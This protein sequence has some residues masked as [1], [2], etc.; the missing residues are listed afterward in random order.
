MRIPNMRAA[1]RGLLR[2]PRLSLAIVLCVA[3]GMTAA[4]AV[5]AFVGPALLR[6]LPFPD[7]ERLVRVWLSSPGESQRVDLS[8]PDLAD[9]ATLRTLDRLEV[10]GRARLVFQWPDG[11][12]RTEGEA[13]SAGYFDLLGA[14]PALGRFPDTDE[15]VRGDRIM[16]LSH[17]TWGAHFGFDRNVVGQAIATQ[18]GPWTVVGV[19]EAGFSGT[20]EEDSGD[21]EF[22]VP[23]DALW[24]DTRQTRRDQGNI[25]SV[26]R[27]APSVTVEQAALE[28]RGL[29]ERVAATHPDTRADLIYRLEPFGENWREHARGGGVLLIAAAGLLLLVAAVNVAGLLLARALERHRELAVRIALGASR[30]RAAATLV[31]EAV[32]LVAIGGV[33]GVLIGPMVL[34]LF[35]SASP[36]TLPEYVSRSPGFAYTVLSI[37]AMLLTALI[38]SGAPAFLGTRADPM[39]VIRE[40]GRGAMGGR[41]ERRWGS[42]LVIGEVALTVVLVISAGLLGRS[43]GVLRGTDL[44]FRTERVLR[45]GFFPDPLDAVDTADVRTLVRRARDELAR[46]PGV[47]TVAAVSPTVPLWYSPDA[48][49]RFDGMPADRV[50]SGIAAGWFSID[51]HFLDAMRIPVLAGR[52]FDGTERPDGPRVAL[53]SESLAAHF[54]GT[55]AAL[56]REIRRENV[57]Y[58]IIGV[59]ADAQFTGPR[60]N[61][62]DGTQLYTPTDQDPSRVVSFVLTTRGAPSNV[63]PEAR[64]VLA[65]LAPRSALDWVESTEQALGLMYAR[66]RF[67]VALVGAFSAAALLLAAVGLFAVLANLV[68]RSRA[69]FG[70]R[71]ALGAGPARITATILWRGLR[72]VC[73]G[74]AVGLPAAFAASRLVQASLFGVASLDPMT[75]IGAAAALLATGTLAAWLPARRAAR[76]SPLDAFRA[77]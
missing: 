16:V 37:F 62:A 66:D 73:I 35:L 72:L 14:R 44:G 36:M 77:E 29:S 2:A 47:E 5:F 22:W 75:W 28:L 57:A 51:E 30:S 64:R 48:A 76:T 33:A 25:W 70:L 55:D 3:L 24:T 11:G 71:Q 39:R 23:L 38:A 49:M 43:L 19:A 65:R 63:A 40:G 53:V 20:V 21:I 54:G 26:A 1:A 13:I 10:S 8:Y 7:A 42:A 58:R 68:A 15:Y 50:T 17:A 46:I 31:A 74:L 52:G 67:V 69:E 61:G 12:R 18:L 6:P 27:L 9:L 56:G 60:P 45:I 59:V 41:T 4:G 32:L 34:D